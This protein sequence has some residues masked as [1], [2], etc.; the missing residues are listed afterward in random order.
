YPHP[1]TPRL[2]SFFMG[3]SK[4][5]GNSVLQMPFRV[6]RCETTF[7]HLRYDGGH[8]AGYNLQIEPEALVLSI[9]DVQADHL[10]EA[11]SVL[12]ADLPQSSQPWKGLKPPFL[13]ARVV[14]VLIRQA[15]ARPD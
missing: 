13:P 1:T 4:I 15:R 7:Y 9:P 2:I 8:R 11:S 3:F 10:R 5:S 6:P 14:G 12:P